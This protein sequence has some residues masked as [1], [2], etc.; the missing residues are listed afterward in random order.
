MSG[1]GA[2]IGSLGSVRDDYNTFMEYRGGDGKITR[3][4]RAN[5]TATVLL[6]ALFVIGIAATTGALSGV[7]TATC[8]SGLGGGAMVTQLLGGNLK[9]RK[10]DVLTSALFAT[11]LLVVGALGFGGVLSAAQMGQG[12]I[13]TLL[14]QGAFYFCIARPIAHEASLE[15]GGSGGGSPDGS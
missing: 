13:G 4:G 6:V 8:V 1:A 14:I 3:S 5:H 12:V 7:A 9:N 10:F 2:F 11:T 15:D